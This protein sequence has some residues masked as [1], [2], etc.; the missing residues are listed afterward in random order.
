MITSLYPL[1]LMI[2][3]FAHIRP[4]G[5]TRHLEAIAAA[6][7]DHLNDALAIHRQYTHADQAIRGVQLY[8][9]QLLRLHEVLYTYC[10]QSI[11]EELNALHRLEEVL[12]N[13]EF[14]FK[15]D[16]NPLTPLPQHHEERIRQYMDLHLEGT[17]DRLRH[18]QIPQ[19]YLDEVHSAIASLLQ[20]GKIPYM[21]YHHQHYLIQLIDALR[22]LADDERQHKNWPFRFLIL[23]IN[24]NFNHIGFLNRWKELYE[25]DPA[26]TENL[27]QYPQHFS[28]IPG[29]AYDPNRSSLL[30]LMCQYIE[31]ETADDKSSNDIPNR[32]I[33]SNLNGKELKIWLHLCVK[34]DITRS[35]EKKEVAEE[36]SKLVKTKEGILLSVH[37][38]T[39]MDR[40]SE[41][42][43]AVHIRKVLKTMLNELHEKFPELNG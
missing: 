6:C 29:F 16:I 14:L 15:R 38:L 13:I 4:S 7:T 8:H 27:L 5:R 40:G 34:A 37:S 19:P 22:Q 35:S 12:E 20:R 39:K 42:P 30:T 41:F 11:A 33:H 31:T 3:N 43:A 18:K 28:T 1:M 21:Q 24:F 32:F 10:D 2:E 25:S 9:T 17:L 26:A 36:F 23:M